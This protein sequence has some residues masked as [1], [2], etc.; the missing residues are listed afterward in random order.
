MEAKPIGTEIDILTPIS[1][2]ARLFVGVEV[3]GWA[4]SGKLVRHIKKS[5]K[6]LEENMGITYKLSELFMSIKALN[7]VSDIKWLILRFDNGNELTQED[8][9]ILPDDGLMVLDDIIIQ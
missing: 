5:V 7:M 9:L 3:E 6:F 4:S 2:H 1:F 8:I